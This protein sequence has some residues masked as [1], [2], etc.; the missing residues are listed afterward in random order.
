MFGNDSCE[1]RLVFCGALFFAYDGL[2]AGFYVV[3]LFDLK[4][5]MV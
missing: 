3:V 1:G 4:M 2:L 5:V